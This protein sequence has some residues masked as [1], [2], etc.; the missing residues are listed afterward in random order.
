MAAGA[1]EV[2]RIDS[3]KGAFVGPRSGEGLLLPGNVYFGPALKQGSDGAWADW[4][5]WH[6]AFQTAAK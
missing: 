3:A 5:N 1:A 6:Q 4:S 2:P